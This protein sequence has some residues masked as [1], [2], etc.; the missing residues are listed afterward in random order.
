MKKIKPDRARKTKAGKAIMM[1]EKKE[2][3]IAEE[4]KYALPPSPRSRITAIVQ[5]RKKPERVVR[6]RYESTREPR[7]GSSFS[8]NISDIL[9]WLTILCFPFGELSDLARAIMQ[10]VIDNCHAKRNVRYPVKRQNCP[11]PACGLLAY[12]QRTEAFID[13]EQF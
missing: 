9:D 4:I 1:G 3:P 10:G 7:E 8:R 12:N 6:V 13:P 2:S 5:K 11:M